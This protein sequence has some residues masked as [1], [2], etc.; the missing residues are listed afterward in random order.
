MGADLDCQGYDPVLGPGP[1]IRDIPSR[2]GPD[3]RRR[4]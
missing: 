4:D 3:R 2:Y 1:G